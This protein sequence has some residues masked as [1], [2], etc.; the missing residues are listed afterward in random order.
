MLLV[1]NVVMTGVISLA[2]EK[3]LGLY[4]KASLSSAITGPMSAV[5]TTIHFIIVSFI[6]YK[7]L[8]PL[9]KYLKYKKA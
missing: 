3:A 1:V 2:I 9:G 8:D 6:A 7:V 4:F 5:S